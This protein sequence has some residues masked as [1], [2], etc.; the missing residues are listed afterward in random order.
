[1]ETFKSIA[2]THGIHFP[3]ILILVVSYQIYEPA[4]SLSFNQ[5][6]APQ[7]CMVPTS[8]DFVIYTTGG[9]REPLGI[10]L[11]WK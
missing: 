5:T 10:K 1:M 9:T 8:Q 3:K 2:E 6:V 7:L 4:T 11:S